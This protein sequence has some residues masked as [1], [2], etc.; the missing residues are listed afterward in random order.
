MASHVA[1]QARRAA[2]LIDAVANAARGEAPAAKRFKRPA[3]LKDRI[4]YRLEPVADWIRR[5]RE[6]STARAL[7]EEASSILTA[8][9]RPQ[10]RTPEGVLVLDLFAQ[11]R[12]LAYSLRN[13]AA[14]I[15]REDSQPAKDGPR[16]SDDDAA[17]ALIH[18][19][20]PPSRSPSRIDAAIGLLT[21]HPDWSDPEIAEQVGCTVQ[22]LS[23]SPRYR[24]ARDGVRALNREQLRRAPKVMGRDMDMYPDESSRDGN[25][26]G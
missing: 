18:D 15:E 2:E 22:N 21:A 16:E 5:R 23:Q 25:S 11:C 9:E 3:A 20:E 8:M 17:T 4:A 24:I 26:V 6:I 1:E 13:W 10:R 7:M 12:R 14:D 19:L